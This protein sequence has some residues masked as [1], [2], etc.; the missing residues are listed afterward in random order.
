MGPKA[1]PGALRKEKFLTPAR[2][3]R[4]PQLSSQ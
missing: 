1:G 2:N 4:I 3:R